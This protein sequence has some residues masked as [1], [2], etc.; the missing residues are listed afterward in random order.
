V[1]RI[2]IVVIA[3]ALVATCAAVAVVLGATHHAAPAAAAPLDPVRGKPAEL[4]D[5]G[6]LALPLDGFGLTLLAREASGNASGN[7]VISPLSIADVLSMILNGAQ[8]RTATEMRHTLGLDGL[9]LPETDQAWAD[10]IASAQAGPRPAVQI[11]DSVWLRSGVAFAPQFLTTGRDYFA[12]ATL[13]LPT[14]ATRAAAAVNDW[15]DGRTSGLI[16]QIVQPGDFSAA[17]ILA[18][19][20]TVHVKAAWK[21]PFEAGETASRPFTLGDGTVARVP[22]MSGSF[23]APVAQTSAYDAVALPTKS[24]VTAWVVVPHAGQTPEALVSLLAT[25]GLDSLYAAARTAS[26]ALELPRL[27]TTFSEPDLKTELQAMG[28]VSAFSP[29]TAELQ[30]I[31]APDTPGRV[32]IERVVHKAVLN[33]NEGG[34]EAAAATA[35][36]VGL[37]AAPYAPLTISADHPFLLLLTDRR[38]AAPLFMAVIRDPRS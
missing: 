7:V 32:Y 2:V 15:V 35:G 22:T 13:P 23:T 27:H 12:A 14:D 8:G 20:N 18:V 11:A 6:R 16:K 31:V 5:A 30:G 4:A 24:P 1:R 33:V 25:R 9:S 36:I 26:V 3:G 29:Q 38:T 17:T 21:V 37:S 34:V 28:M 19:V 10:L